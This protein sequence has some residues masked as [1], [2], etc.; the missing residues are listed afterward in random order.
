M[1]WQPNRLLPDIPLV[2]EYDMKAGLLYSLW[3]HVACCLSRDYQEADQE[4]NHKVDQKVSQNAHDGLPAAPDHHSKAEAGT[5]LPVS[6]STTLCHVC[7]GIF[8]G[9]LVTGEGRNMPHHPS[10]AALKRA[11]EEGCSICKMIAPKIPPRTVALGDSDLSKTDPIF[12][13]LNLYGGEDYND[14]QNGGYIDYGAIVITPNE[15]A[16]CFRLLGTRYSNAPIVP[17][18]PDATLTDHAVLET[19]RSWLQNCRQT[20]A[21]CGSVNP[22]FNP[23]RLIYIHDASSVQ[24]IETKKE[25]ET[26][27]YVA[28]SH[29]WGTSKH[30]TLLQDDPDTQTKGNIEQLLL[31]PIQVET[32]PTSYRE[33][34]SVSLALGFR[35][36]WID[37]LC[38]IQNSREDW[39]REAAMMKDVYAN[40]SLNLCA[41]AA[42]DSSE[43]SF[44]HRTSSVI[45][46]LDIEPRW[47]GILDGEYQK[48]KIRPLPSYLRHVKFKLVNASMYQTDMRDA[49][50]NL[51]AWVVQERYLSKRH[52]YMTCNQL[53]W[54]CHDILACEVLPA[55]VPNCFDY[56]SPETDEDERTR[57]FT[58]STR[59]HHTARDKTLLEG[60]PADQTEHAKE[61]LSL[62]TQQQD[63]QSNQEVMYA[64]WETLVERYTRCKI[65]YPSDKLPALSGLAQAFSIAQGSEFAL[66]A[67]SYLA[68]LWRP[69]LPRALCWAVT[70]DYQT[71]PCDQYR[72]PSWS[73]TS[74][75]GMINFPELDPEAEAACR[76]LD[77]NMAYEDERYKAGAVKGGILH[78]RCH[79][80]EVL[81]P[82]DPDPEGF[83]LTTATLISPHLEARAAEAVKGAELFWDLY[84][85]QSGRFA[86]GYFDQLPH[87]VRSDGIV[88]GTGAVRKEVW[89]D[90]LM[91]EEEP[92]VR[93]SL[94]PVMVTPGKETLGLVLCQ[95]VNNDAGLEGL[96][97]E[98]VFQRV[99]YFLGRSLEK[100]V[101]D[102]IPERTIA[103]V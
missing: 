79:V 37:S 15:Y 76:V 2:K 54:E 69:F 43:A 27:P 30:L 86:I 4:T 50:L 21:L 59:S 53:W 45:A 81:P 52:L 99:G 36:I 56:W 22:T 90:A 49:P 80:V 9:L 5:E 88:K 23:T 65:T 40:G 62:P 55:G 103:I 94:V 11:A 72:A 32:L 83:V 13:S 41:S 29:C 91:E 34:I 12:W 87:A 38:I 8:T 61:T 67:N 70:E 1:S 16:C 35:H 60:D 98:A 77:V 7:N 57:F 19:A 18:R 42:A 100:E 24:L 78:L 14:Q 44:Q 48:G 89:L 93:V 6:S 51:R 33:G 17:L 39:A 66:D 26:H 74:G 46:P 47:T 84:D 31:S 63:R 75:E 10:V 3:K 92:R 85:R 101:L 96:D 58:L 82:F 95:V 102:L 25:T 97:G 28:F 68:G 20:H 64:L 71:Y 73:W